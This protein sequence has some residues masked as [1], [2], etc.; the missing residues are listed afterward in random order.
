MEVIQPGLRLTIVVIVDKSIDR[1][2]DSFKLNY[3]FCP[4]KRKNIQF[5]VIQDEEK[6]KILIF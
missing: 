6:Q 3:L 2:L 5:T 1:F 4:T